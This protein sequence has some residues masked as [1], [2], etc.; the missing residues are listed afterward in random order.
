M[1]EIY[2]KKFAV[3]NRFHPVAA[4]PDSVMI[5]LDASRRIAQSLTIKL[6]TFSTPNH[7]LF[8]TCVAAGHGLNLIGFSVFVSIY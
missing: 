8:F 3:S 7:D 4:P 2:P 6:R 1:T 5:A